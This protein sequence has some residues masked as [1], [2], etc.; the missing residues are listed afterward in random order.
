[1]SHSVAFPLPQHTSSESS[2]ATRPGP[3]PWPLPLSGASLS[4]DVEAART[5]TRPNLDHLEPH[6]VL[7]DLPNHD[8]RVGL[9][10][11]GLE[12][13]AGL[14]REPD[15]P[16]VMIVDRGRLLGVVSRRR[17]FEKLGRPFGVEMYLRRPVHVLL[18]IA[19]HDPLTLDADCDIGAAA[20]TA[21]DR[22]VELLY[23]P[24]VVRLADGECRLL[25]LSILLLAQSRLLALANAAIRAQVRAAEEAANAKSQFLANMSHEIRTP[26]NGVIGM[27][28]LLL[29]TP[30]NAEQRDYVEVIRSSGDALLSIINDILDFSKIESGKLALEEAPFDLRLCIEDALDLLSLRAS[31]KRL[32][33]AYVVQEGTPT[34]LVGDVTRLRQILV[35]LLSNAVKFTEGGE[36]TVTVDARPMQGDVMEWRFAVRDTGIGIDPDRLDQLFRPFSQVDAST[37]RKYGGTGLGLSICK[38]LAEAMGGTMWVESTPGVGSTFWFTLR[39]AAAP[40]PAAVCDSPAI[41]H[42]RGKRLLV[43]EDNATNRLILTRQAAAWGMDTVAFEEPAEALARLEAGE[44]F[45]VAILDLRMPGIDGV[46]LGARIR[47]IPSARDLPLVLLSSV[48]HRPDGIEE[49]GFAAVTTKPIKGTQLCRV[50]VQA[51]GGAPYRTPM[52]AGSMGIDADLGRRL[53]LRILLADDN[54]VNQKVIQ[55]M[56]RKLGYEADTVANGAEALYE[57]RRGRYDLAFMDV[58][59]PEMDGLEAARRVRQHLPKESRPLVI[60]LTAAASRRDEQEC[61]AAGM[62]GYLRKPVRIEELQCAIETWG[63]QARRAA[64]TLPQGTD[65]RATSLAVERGAARATARA[66]DVESAALVDDAVPLDSMMVGELLDQDREDP[67][68]LR[69]LVDIYVRTSTPAV[70]DLEERLREGD[71]REVARIAHKLKGSSAVMGA[72]RLSSLCQTLETRA[73]KGGD[74]LESIVGQVCAEF[75]R[76]AA[77]L[78][79]L[80]AGEFELPD[81]EGAADA[82]EDALADAAPEPVIDAAIREQLCALSC[83]D[84]ERLAE[85]TLVF[86]AS[87]GGRIALLQDASAAGDV[88]GMVTIAQKIRN[89]SAFVGARRLAEACAR[90]EELAPGEAPERIRD[91]VQDMVDEYDRAKAVLEELLPQEGAS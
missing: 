25:D 22:P 58:Q 37:T 70:S 82:V 23:E 65:Q 26:M 87:M 89:G 49:V 5:L 62:A 79:R 61:L 84:P 83:D 19:V 35:N 55:A 56:L 17:M 46:T 74:E 14:R 38:R 63:P 68:T 9:E 90:I 8:Y 66:S 75:R 10:T 78:E 33:L 91:L 88:T 57:L 72:S 29:D 4:G 44:A 42:L 7:A 86:A 64:P 71:L 18:D 36:V 40:E 85:F 81:E 47:R 51:L 76:A 30:L 53:P 28:G 69:E 6:A 31:A 13:E 60:A 34:H 21:L 73:E 15:L 24:I 80:A 16:G 45:D 41:E 67:G 20:Q 59:M 2:T 32:D 3:R 12:V 43:V 27:T 11:L 54:A 52:R 39:T 1:M 77:S 50:L 48:G